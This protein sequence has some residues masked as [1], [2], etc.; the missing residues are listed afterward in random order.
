MTYILEDIERTPVQVQ[1]FRSFLRI[2]QIA[3]VFRSHK[4]DH[5]LLKYILTTTKKSEIFYMT[6]CKVEFYFKPKLIELI[7]KAPKTD[8]FSIYQWAL[9]ILGPALN[10]NMASVK[11]RPRRNFAL[12]KK[13]ISDALDQAKTKQKQFGTSLKCK[14][15]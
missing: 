13:R 5:L 7:K 12:G 15:L 14:K 11:A 2:A 3:Q 1:K 9:K 6:C 4:L 10:A 8:K